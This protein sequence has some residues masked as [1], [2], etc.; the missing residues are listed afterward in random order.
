MQT[1]TCR[2]SFS[3][4]FSHIDQTK[5][6]LFHI[7]IILPRP[8]SGQAETDLFTL[9]DVALNMIKLMALF[10][11]TASWAVPEDNRSHDNNNTA[12]A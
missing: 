1:R 3:K 8:L 12:A 7:H 5:A 4:M 9:I 11:Q 10:Y 2:R 6:F